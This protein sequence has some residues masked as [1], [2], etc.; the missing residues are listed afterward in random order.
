MKEDKIF[1][2]TLYVFSIL[3]FLL[4]VCIFGILL[5]TSVD[6]TPQL[7]DGQEPSSY[8]GYNTAIFTTLKTG[9]VQ[10][11]DLSACL[12]GTESTCYY[13]NPTTPYTSTNFL[14]PIIPDYKGIK[15]T[16][17]IAIS[18]FIM[19]TNEL[20]ILYG[21]DIPIFK[22][23]GYTIYLV[24]D[25]TYCDGKAVLASVADTVNNVNSKFTHNKKFV[26][27]FGMNTD[28]ID[29]FKK[30]IDSS[31]Q[32]YTVLFP[33]ING[34]N[35]SGR[36]IVIGR[37]A[38]PENQEA[39]DIYYK[40][41]KTFG[42]VIKYFRDVD[43]LNTV[44]EP[45]FI[46]RNTF[47][48]EYTEFP[49]ESVFNSA[50]ENYLVN[51]LDTLPSEYRYVYDIDTDRYLSEISYDNGYDCI[52]NC[53]ICNIDNRDTV[54]TEQTMPYLILPNQSIVAVF[55]VNHS[56]YG[57]SLY[58]NISVYNNENETGLMSVDYTSDNSEFYKLIV[59]PN[60]PG[61][62][63]PVPVGTYRYILPDNVTK[64]SI[65]ERAYVQIIGPNGYDYSG[66]S[67]DYST[68]IKP[69]TW[70]ISTSPNPPVYIKDSTV[71]TSMYL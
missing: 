18:S 20:F 7:Q 13:Q 64:I 63:L 33:V 23:W 55:G 6:R 29:K 58:T 8:L 66:I 44:T 1:R 54:Y 45:L 31:V 38:L 67:A 24:N 10:S 40:D 5:Y 50:A 65:Y 34:K 22:Y 17:G 52:N 71:T 59:T 26:I 3:T 46:P 11:T 39:A 16:T 49:G 56:V 37:T 70:I 68:L 9:K 42:S 36:M 30:S 19:N 32:V 51:V 25:S 43:P 41:T 69:K 48:N 4:V 12:D 35:T 47:Y 53:T 2:I 14:Y 15:I 61:D 28:T 60:P 62:T 27:V 21:D 57:K